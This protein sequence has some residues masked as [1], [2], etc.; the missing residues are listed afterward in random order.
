VTATLTVSL[1][2]V[3]VAQA[4][5]SA[6][7]YVPAQGAVAIILIAMQ[8]GLALQQGFNLN[9][10]CGVQAAAAATAAALA[11]NATSTANASVVTAETTAVSLADGTFVVTLR[12]LAAC[13]SFTLAAAVSCSAAG[14]GG[15]LPGF[16]GD[17]QALAY[18]PLHAY[19]TPCDPPPLPGP[20]GNSGGGGVSTAVVAGSVAGAVALVAAAAAGGWWWCNRRRQWRAKQ[21]A[22]GPDIELDAAS[23]SGGLYAAMPAAVDLRLSGVQ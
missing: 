15:C 19:T 20:G 18:A 22:S 16:F 12:G 3:G 11:T 7:P 6:A 8:V 14:A 2:G 10:A 1:A 4:D 9:A 21:H 17:P 5:A 23:A 13:S